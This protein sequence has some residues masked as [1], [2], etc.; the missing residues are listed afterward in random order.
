MNNQ[1]GMLAA[2][3]ALGGRGASRPLCRSTPSP[4]ARTAPGH[5]LCRWTWPGRASQPPGTGGATHG[6]H[7]LSLWQ[8]SRPAWQRDGDTPEDAPGIRMECG[9]PGSAVLCSS[10][11]TG[12]AQCRARG[13]DGTVHTGTSASPHGVPGPQLP[14]HHAKDATG[15]PVGPRQGV[16]HRSE[17]LLLR[18]GW[19]RFTSRDPWEGRRRLSPTVTAWHPRMSPQRLRASSVAQLQAQRD[20]VASCCHGQGA[21]L[22]PQPRQEPGLQLGHPGGVGAAT[23]RAGRASSADPAG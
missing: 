20:R 16:T 11:W 13:Q 14:Q 6:P 1:E 8:P 21:P 3:S 19:L 22:S 7:R 9:S 5:S 10:R 12:T 18:V 15:C 17:P 2:A 23:G 4:W